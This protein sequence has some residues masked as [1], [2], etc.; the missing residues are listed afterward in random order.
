[1]GTTTLI[2]SNRPGVSGS[3]FGWR[4]SGQSIRWALRG[5]EC[6]RGIRTGSTRLLQAVIADPGP[7][8][9]ARQD[10]DRD[11]ALVNMLTGLLMWIAHGRV[12]Q[13]HG[14]GIVGFSGGMTAV[15]RVRVDQRHGGQRQHDHQ[16]QKND[17]SHSGK[18]W[19]NVG[20]GQA[21]EH[22]AADNRFSR[23]TCAAALRD[24]FPD[25]IT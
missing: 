1:M 19:H 9:R 21:H 22:A 23:V 14:R 13:C 15:C 25:P 5:I 16:K 24:G 12:A 3:E 8:F 11:A 2:A 6:G 7:G 18:C 4:Y 17:S 20:P 10:R